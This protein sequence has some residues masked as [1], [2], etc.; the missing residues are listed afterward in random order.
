M[1]AMSGKKKLSL[2]VSAFLIV[3]LL[4]LFLSFKLVVF[5][6]PEGMSDYSSRYSHPSFLNPGYLLVS[7]SDE[8]PSLLERIKKPA[9]YIYTPY[10]SLDDDTRS[11]KYVVIHDGEK[12]TIEIDYKE[13]YSTFLSQYPERKIALSYESSSEEDSSLYEELKLLYPSLEKI[14]YDGRVSV[15]NSESLIAKADDMWAVIISDAITSSSLYR[16]T[17]AR[18]VMIESDA[19]SSLSL[20]SVISLSLDWAGIIRDVLSGDDIS[21][22]YTF[23]VLH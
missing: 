23:S 8:K 2:V 15:V 5:V 6:Y 17:K 12:K 13:L 18:V 9:V 1:H 4:F 11:S 14:E 7:R 22:Y 20:E 3:L 16:N 19:V 10:S 21:P